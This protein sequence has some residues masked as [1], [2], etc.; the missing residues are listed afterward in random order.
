MTER[1][2]EVRLTLDAMIAITYG[3]SVGSSSKNGRILVL[4]AYQ[5]LHKKLDRKYPRMRRPSSC[6]T[7]QVHGP[8]G[9]ILQS[10]TGMRMKTYC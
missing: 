8:R 6:C 3:K 4:V 5:E 1:V 2:V 9:Q 7:G 10:G